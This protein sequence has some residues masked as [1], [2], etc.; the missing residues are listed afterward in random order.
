MRIDSTKAVPNLRTSGTLLWI[1]HLDLY[2][3]VENKNRSYVPWI[4]EENDDD[5]DAE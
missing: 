5:D 4:D 2:L 1:D 3:T